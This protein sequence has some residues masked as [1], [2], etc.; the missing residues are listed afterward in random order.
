MGC[1]HALSKMS[2]AHPVDDVL[3][4]QRADGPSEQQGQQR[5]QLRQPGLLRVCRAGILSRARHLR[6]L[7]NASVA[8]DSRC[9]HAWG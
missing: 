1:V 3:R 9:R 8:I 5:Q 4:D 7:C 2:Y 6:I